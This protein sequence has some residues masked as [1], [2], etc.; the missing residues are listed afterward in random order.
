MGQIAAEL[1]QI[2][3]HFTKAFGYMP[4]LSVRSGARVSMP[5]MMDTILNVGLDNDTIADWQERL[6][7]ECAM[8]SSCRLI[9]MYGSVVKGIPRHDFEGK[10]L[11][12]R[13]DLYEDKTGESFPDADGQIL[14]A[15]KA[16]FDSW[17]N[18]R[19][20]VYRKMHN[21]PE[22]WGTAV[23]LQAMVFGNLNN[24][25]ATG[26][27]F[28]RNPDSGENVV[29]GEYLVN[30]QGEDVVAGIRTPDPLTGMADWNVKVYQELM[31]TVATLEKTRKDMQDV[32]F[33]IMDGK[34]YVLQTRNAKR[35][36]RAAVRIAVDMVEEKLI[37]PKVALKRVTAKQFDLAQQS[38]IDPAFTEDAD[39]VGIPACSGVVTGVVM[40][41]AKSAIDCKTPCILVTQE[42]TPDDIAGMVAAKAVLT[43]TGGATSHA[44]VVARSMDKPCV[45]GLGASLN[46]FSV[47]E[48]ISIDGA[49]GRV[50]RKEVPV[51]DGG[52]DPYIQKFRALL[53]GH[54]GC[55]PMG[56]KGKV[57]ML[58]L[59]ELPYLPREEA[60]SI[61][62]E[63]L[64]QG[65][66]VVDLSESHSLQEKMFFKSF[67]TK[68]CRVTA[69]L[70]AMEKTLTEEEKSALT[71][72]T[73]KTTK[74]T[75]LPS[76]STLEELV[77]HDEGP[78]IW[79]G[80][81][82]PAA[83]KV[84]EWKLGLGVTLTSMGVITKGGYVY[85]AQ[86]IDKYLGA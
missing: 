16:V 27:L 11:A 61:V 64:S 46:Q 4:L 59:P 8:D 41:S 3:K 34:L 54:S 39:F 85:E 77:L 63:A 37:T 25:S 66:V 65:P 69:L 38:V 2:K 45:V 53:W 29:T 17:D 51:I 32:E 75:T 80:K 20:K 68:V 30:A 71:V 82:S 26:V 35:S 14:G 70:A 18:D 62:R 58:R 24:Q 5:G 9:E 31:T 47:G 86:L 84:L 56:L 7:Y 40:K 55:K 83:K 12:M 1:P 60:L 42:T 76:A 22:E 13:V 57:E 44:A 6:G 67:M 36:A 28:T 23:V 10:D 21:I 73:A 49:T 15:I 43:M 78:L 72:L 79:S 50:W 52:S 19:A 48:T 81:N 33:T 74:L